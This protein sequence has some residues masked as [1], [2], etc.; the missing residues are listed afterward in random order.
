M[1]KLYLG[2]REITPIKTIQGQS[3]EFANYKVTNGVA[4]KI[5]GPLAGNE[6]SNITSVAD[7]GMEYSFYECHNITG[8][9]DLS[10]ITSVG[11]NGLQHAFYSC[12][13][14]TSVDLSSL[15]TIAEGGFNRTFLWCSELESVD[16]SSLTTVGESGLTDAFSRTNIESVSFPSLS[17]IDS[18]GFFWA[19]SNC[20]NLK[21]LYFNSLNS[22]SFD[23]SETNFQWM[24]DGCSDVT[25]HFPVDLEAV[26][27]DWWDVIDGFGGSN[28][29]VLFDL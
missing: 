5:S 1:A 16:L 25:V 15:T 14:I 2:S 24:L 6:F 23:G 3:S 29:T 28:T 9:L 19:F 18:E 26:I 4:S 17:F 21:T 11:V 8:K 12:E 7:N 22:N 27:G 13:R 20:Y 10:S